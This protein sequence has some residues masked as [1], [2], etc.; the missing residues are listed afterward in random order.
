MILLYPHLRNYRALVDTFVIGPAV[1]AG[2]DISRGALQSGAFIT[3]VVLRDL[4]VVQI[5]HGAFRVLQFTI[6]QLH[7]DTKN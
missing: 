4:T 2:Y 1:A 5:V 7:W 6:L 3:L